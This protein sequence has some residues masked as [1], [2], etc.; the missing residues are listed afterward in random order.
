MLFQ[1]GEYRQSAIA[2]LR[3]L[4]M[5]DDQYEQA[6]SLILLAMARRFAGEPEA[7][8]VALMRVEE[9]TGGLA[10]QFRDDQHLWSHFFATRA[11][12]NRARGHDEAAI[13][14]AEGAA[15]LFV[16]QQQ[17]WKAANLLNN[18]AIML[19]DK[20]ALSEAH[21]R[22]LEAFDHL[23]RQPH[24]QTRACL[25][26]SLGQVYARMSS[27][28]QR[29]LA[30]GQ[31]REAINL[32][33]EIG[34]KLQAGNS[35]IQLARY[36]RTYWRKEEARGALARAG[37]LALEIGSEELREEVRAEMNSLHHARLLREET[38]A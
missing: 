12:V 9:I 32:F 29:L 30:E 33:L 4:R 17:Y 16:Q 2:A 10:G 28:D 8:H 23:D 36:L 34:N 35:L 15:E 20:G 31:F 26:D 21:R 14:D 6:M 18:V 11:S 7:A 37:E 3:S 27:H 25:C 5:T 38:T 22:L 1:R 13:C 24:M 19:I